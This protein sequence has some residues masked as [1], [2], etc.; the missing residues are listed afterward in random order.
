MVVHQIGGSNRFL[1]G[2]KRVKTSN[3]TRIFY[4]KFSGDIT[5]YFD[6]KLDNNNNNNNVLTGSDF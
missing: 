4:S 3:V 5:K 1:V 6:F 2:N